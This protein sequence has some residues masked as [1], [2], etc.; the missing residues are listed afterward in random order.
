MKLVSFSRHVTN[1]G[2]LRYMLTLFGFTKDEAD[3][4]IRDWLRRRPD[5][6]V[7]DDRAEP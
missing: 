6:V 7:A 5:D 4:V 3:P 1:I 2:L